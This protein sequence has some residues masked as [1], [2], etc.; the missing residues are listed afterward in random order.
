MITSGELALERAEQALWLPE[1][2][3]VRRVVYTQDAYGSTVETW[4]NGNTYACRVSPAASPREIAL[5]GRLV[6]EAGLTVTLPHGAD[7]RPDDRL[8]VG[9]RTFDVIGVVVGGAW[10]TVLRVL[11]KEVS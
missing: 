8:V 2:C 6:H 10:Q 1:T 7:V 11:V 9:A 3:T 4:A 5:A